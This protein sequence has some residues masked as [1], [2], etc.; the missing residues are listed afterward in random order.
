MKRERERVCV[1]VRARTCVGLHSVFLQV[2][3]LDTI[4]DNETC[5]KVVAEAMTYL[6]NPERRHEFHS[7]RIAFRKY[8]QIFHEYTVLSSPHQ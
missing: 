1:C 8:K 4:K 7:T 2:D 3:I 6:S 5:R